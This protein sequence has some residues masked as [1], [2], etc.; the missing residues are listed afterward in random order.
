MR[1]HTLPILL[2]SA[3]ATALSAQPPAAPIAPPAI[4]SPEVAADRRVTFRIAARNATAVSVGIEG[5]PSRPMQKDDKGVWSLTTES[6]EPDFYGYSFNVDGARVFDS[7]NPGLVPNLLNPRSLLHVP[8]DPSLP[9]EIGNVP[10][11]TVHRHVYASPI[12]GDTRDLYVYTPPG[13][14][15]AAATR[16]PVLY[17]L[18]GFSD[19]ASGWTAVGMANVILDNLIAHGAA[20]PM[21]VAMPLGYGAPE[22]VHMSPRTDALGEKNIDRFSDMMISEIIPLVERSYKTATDRGSRAIAG[23]SM[24]GGEALVVGLNHLDRFAAVAG[25][26]SAVREPFESRFPHLTSAASDH[27]RTLWIACGTSD[28]LFEGNRKLRDWLTAKQVRVTAIDTPGAHTWMVWRRN[29]A[30]F[31]PLLFK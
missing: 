2:L 20:R 14:D 11:G 21:I 24:G 6:L 9:W 31:A 30:A 19:D 16:Y 25:F 8:G 28:G 13:Y 22:V 7:A 27:L 12:G 18:H 23:L 3:A 17:L 10:H 26:S 15:A 1:L 4:R 5:S 29:L